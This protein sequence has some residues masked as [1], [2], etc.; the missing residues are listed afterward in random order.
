MK[1][2][3]KQRGFFWWLKEPNGQ[4]N[5]R[6]TSVP[7]LLTISQQGHIRLD[8]DRALWYSKPLAPFSLGNP[9]LLPHGKWIV[10]KLG[11]DGDGDHVLLDGLE[12]ADFH[13]GEESLNTQSYEAEMCIATESPFSVDFNL[14]SFNQLRVELAGLEEWL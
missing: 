10:G 2:A 6:E 7:G 11:T 13:V 5:S 3:I 12:R 14:E 4:T 9:R 1:N 8:L